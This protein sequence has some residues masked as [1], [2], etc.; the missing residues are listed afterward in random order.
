MLRAR[1]MKRCQELHGVFLGRSN[2]CSGQRGTC[3]NHTRRVK[4]RPLAGFCVTLV[5]IQN[6]LCIQLVPASARRWKLVLNTLD[7]S[8]PRSE[9]SDQLSLVGSAHLTMSASEGGRQERVAA[10]ACLKGV[11]K[12]ALPRQQ[13]T[14]RCRPLG[15]GADS[16]QRQGKREGKRAGARTEGSRP[17]QGRTGRSARVARRTRVPAQRRWGADRRLR[18][19]P[20]CS[21]SSCGPPRRKASSVSP[22]QRTRW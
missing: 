20:Q 3:A 15:W 6:P 14:W 21:I 18:S 5:L 16:S 8:L 2:L 7:V 12:A 4:Y 11:L 10:I 22:R 13:R 19:I 9:L 1:L 17:S